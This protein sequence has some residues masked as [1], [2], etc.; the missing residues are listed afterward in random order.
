MDTRTVTLITLT[1]D[2]I[3]NSMSF[4]NNNVHSPKKTQ[5]A[6]LSKVSTSNSKIP[7]EA[8]IFTRNKLYQDDP[9]N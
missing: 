3:Q 1:G 7:V 4:E 8:P 2:V 9:N 6:K 5:N